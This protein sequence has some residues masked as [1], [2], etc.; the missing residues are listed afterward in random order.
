MKLSEAAALIHT[1]KIITGKPVVC[2]DLGCG[3]GLFTHA[4]ATILH[5]GS[6]IYGVDKH[7]SLINNVTDNH[8]HITVLKADFEKDD[9]FIDKLDGILMANALHYVKEKKRL[10]EKLKPILKPGA[11]FL[12]VEYDTDK[13]VEKWVPY[14]L[15][16]QSLLKFFNS[17]GYHNIHKLH[18]RPSLYGN[19]NIYSSLILL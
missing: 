1:P 3:S 14:P 4:L 17:E 5:E 12:V 9:L 10:L 16:Y 7:P 11:F 13:P 18:E 8:I 2:A 19:G 15:S 6:I